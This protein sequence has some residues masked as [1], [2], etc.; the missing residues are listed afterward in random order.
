MNPINRHEELKKVLVQYLLTT[1]QTLSPTL[2]AERKRLLEDELFLDAFIEALPMY[3][4]WGPVGQLQDADLPNMSED[5][6]RLFKEF[7]AKGLMPDDRRMYMHQHEMLR[8]ALSGQPCMI[9]TGTSS[10][11]TESFL[12]PLLARIINEAVRW[13]PAA[14]EGTPD[15]DPFSGRNLATYNK[16]RETRHED[17]PAAVRAII[18]YPMN[19]LVDDQISRLRRTL[20]SDEVHQFLDANLDRNRITFGKYNGNTPVA[21]HPKKSDGSPNTYAI[22]KLKEEVTKYRQAYSQLKQKRDKSTA[23]EAEKERTEELM[24]F[25]PRVDRDSAEMIYRWE[26]QDTPP[27]IMITNY[28]MLSAMLMRNTDPAITDDK[29]DADIF[30]KTKTWLAEDRTN[31]KF[32]LVIDELHLYRGTAGTEVAYLIRLLLE[33]LGLEPDSEQFC[34]LASSASLQE[35]EKADDF[36]KKFFATSR[37]FQIITDESSRLEIRPGTDQEFSEPDKENLTED[38]LIAHSGFIRNRLPAPAKVSDFQNRLGLSDDQFTKF[39]EILDA[40]HS[41]DIPR[42]RLHWMIR[43][44]PGIFASACPDAATAGDIYRT[45]GTISQ[46]KDKLVDENGNYIYEILFCEHCGT[47]FIS[48]YKTQMSGVMPTDALLPQSANLEALPNGFSETLITRE[49]EKNA[50]VFWSLPKGFKWMINN[51]A[52]VHHFCSPLTNGNQE[53]HQEIPVYAMAGSQGDHDG[54]PVW[55]PASLNPKTGKI[56]LFPA[57]ISQDDIA[58]LYYSSGRPDSEL[59]KAPAMPPICPHCG[60]DHSGNKAFPSPVR[61]IRLGHDRYTQALAKK[62]FSTLEEGNAK[63][64]LAFSDSRESAARLSHGIEAAHW[65]DILRSVIYGELLV[66]VPPAELIEWIKDHPRASDW[67]INTFIIQHNILN[68]EDWFKNLPKVKAWAQNP[69]LFSLKNIT[70]EAWSRL[71]DIGVCP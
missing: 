13:H 61:Q 22:S 15:M 30:E 67:E 62:L 5:G 35:Q 20:D 45:V 36:L 14:P 40:S 43:N 29:S 1:H 2:N 42:Y 3:K 28:S 16:R 48:G 60:N 44:S 37:N 26:M 49:K 34:I 54:N 66:D 6:R 4:T 63:K 51:R 33:R 71:Q 23:D 41:P 58:G 59:E 31:N 39:M 7:I 18:M 57:A 9:T 56:S 68:G 8:K 27:D 64:L 55:K 12:M 24:S 11:K 65:R 32:T 46:Q 47:L 53:N 17:R 10:G 69:D 52:R 38:V 50:G 70:N 21:G 25:F 19:A